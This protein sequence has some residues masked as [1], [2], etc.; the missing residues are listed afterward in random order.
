MHYSWRPTVTE[1]HLSTLLHDSATDLTV[2]DV[3]TRAIVASA[4]RARQR[5]RTTL[6][7]GLALATVAVIGTGFA[8]THVNN[9]TPSLAA[10]SA[11][12]DDGW[13]VAQ[14]STIHLGTGATAKV[15]G[16]VKAM[17]YTSAGTL[18]RVGKTPYTDAPDSNY[19]L[20]KPDGSTIDFSLS[21]GDRKPGTDPTLPY[22]AYAQKDGDSSHWQVVLRD[23][24]TGKVATTIDIKGSFTWGGWVAPPVALSGDHV[25]VGM[26]DATLEVNW[27]TGQVRKA[28]GLDPSKMPTVQAGHEITGDEGKFAIKD[29]HTGTLLLDLS[30]K[31]EAVKSGIVRGGSMPDEFWP[32]LSPDGAWVAL[33][34]SA[35]CRDDDSCHFDKPTA[36]VYNVATGGRSTMSL[37]YGEFGWTPTGSMLEV[38]DGTVLSCD[39]GTHRCSSTPVHLNGSGPIRI[40]GNDN[41]S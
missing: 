24:R 28:T 11:P 36:D 34:P 13:A 8:I 15:P 39:V 38:G 5:R 21:L 16:D 20:V 4:H 1:T 7:G 31:G 27:R 41:E 9:N 33:L 14:G 37:K 40:S 22:I 12:R 19:W 30:G 26:D 3:P 23:V 32:Q 2:P 6:A 17:Y 18:V 35:T 25:Y 10:A 29:A